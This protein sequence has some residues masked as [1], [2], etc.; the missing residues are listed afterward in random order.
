[1]HCEWRLLINWWTI[2]DIITS[3]GLSSLA[4]YLPL[5]SLFYA[6]HC[7]TKYMCACVKRMVCTII[8]SYQTS[9]VYIF[10]HAHKLMDWGGQ[11]HKFQSLSCGHLLE[12]RDC[13]NWVAHCIAFAAQLVRARDKRRSGQDRLPPWSSPMQSRFPNHEANQPSNG[14]SILQSP[15]ASFPSCAVLQ[16]PHSSS[17]VGI[18][19]A[20]LAD[21]QIVE[22]MP[23]C[24]SAEKKRR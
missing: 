8:Y 23:S 12:S 15:T 16:T 22:C 17:D 11:F 18:P 6:K 13:G 2:I 4:H 19:D 9:A 20:L 14:K 3:S 21:S 5:P 10:A 1:M 24:C 7:T